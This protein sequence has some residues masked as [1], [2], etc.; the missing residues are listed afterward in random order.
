MADQDPRVSWNATGMER[1]P[2]GGLSGRPGFFIVQA[3]GLVLPVSPVGVR[4]GSGGTSSLPV[5]SG[6]DLMSIILRKI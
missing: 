2:C 4:E 1:A 6:D 3:R 5:G